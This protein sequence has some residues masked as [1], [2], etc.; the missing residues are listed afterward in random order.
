MKTL[1]NTTKSFTT[2]SDP[3]HPSRH[4]LLEKGCKVL[5]KLTEIEENYRRTMNEMTPET[6][7]IMLTSKWKLAN[8]LSLILAAT[9]VKT[10][11][12]KVLLKKVRRRRIGVQKRKR[13]GGE[14]AQHRERPSNH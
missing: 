14:M 6:L 8:R 2:P 9:T 12:G 1:Q 3:N 4:K 7:A 10:K 13:G 5:W 11:Q